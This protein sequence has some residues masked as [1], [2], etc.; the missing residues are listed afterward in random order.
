VRL[1]RAD[2]E[3][4]MPP[5]PTWFTGRRAAIGFLTDHVLRPDRWRLVPTSA[6]GQPAFVVYERAGDGRYEPHGVQVL[7]LIG[8]HI[9]RVTAFID[10][11]LVPAFERL[12]GASAATSRSPG[13]P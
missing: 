12:S 6:N 3:L 7:T 9:A 4:E 8:A 10:P 5:N 13:R 1:L 11:A 2:V